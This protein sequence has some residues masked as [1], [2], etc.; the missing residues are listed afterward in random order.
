MLLKVLVENNT[1]IDQYYLG[2]PGISFY[3]EDED[4][5][6]LFD[7]G[8]SNALIKNAKAM[9]ISLQEVDTI[10]CSHGHNDHTRGLKYLIQEYDLSNTKM[11][12]HPD[13]FLPKEDGIESFGAPYSIKELH[14]LFHVILTK[15]PYKMSKHMTFLG[16]IPQLNF[17]EQ[18]KKIGFCK[19]EEV[20][21]ND[22]LM[23][24]SAVVY[25]DSEGIFIITGCSHS[26]ICNI[27]EYAKIVCGDHRIKG[28]I[29]GFHLFQ[30]NEVLDKTIQYM[31]EN[32]ISQLYPCHCVSFQVKAKMNEVLH[33]NEVGVGL[34]LIL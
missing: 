13:C 29:G 31:K 24:D 26:G 18:R 34:E 16:E 30:T 9:G 3:I 14:Q 4:N 33:V 21:E 22:Y 2:E 5:K 1:L 25:Q 15:T 7:T 12:A 6:I 11:V 20:L 8:Y 32:K 28:V 10:V 17:F 23:D 27:I 19:R